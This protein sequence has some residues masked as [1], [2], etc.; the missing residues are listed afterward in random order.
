MSDK[1]PI[2]VCNAWFAYLERQRTKTV[3]LQR[4]ASLAREGKVDE[5]R[6][7]KAHIDTQPHVFDGARLAPAVR[8]LLRENAEQAAEIERLRSLAKSVNS[9]LSAKSF[10]RV[11]VDDSGEFNVLMEQLHCLLSELLDEAMQQE[12]EK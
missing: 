5:A 2:D 3:E 10:W 4:A 9:T 1:K 12:A 7:I 11:H 6:R 8:E